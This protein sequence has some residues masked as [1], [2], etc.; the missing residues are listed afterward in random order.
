MSF[1]ISG[2]HEPPGVR[3]LSRAAPWRLLAAR[4]VGVSG[5]V[6]YNWWV[7]VPFRAGLLR[8]VNGFFSDLEATGQP[9]ASLLQH[10]DLLAGVLILAALW[11][12]GSAGRD[13]SRRAEWRWMLLFAVAGA[14]SALYPYACTEGTSAGC[15]TLEW[16]FR[17]PVHHY[18]HVAFGIVEFAA[19]SI[20]AVLAR[21]RSSASSS[22]EARIYRLL[23]PFGLVA[24]PVLGAAYLTDRLGA[25]VEP[26]FF[27]A[28]TL[29]IAT[30]LFEPQPARTQPRRPMPQATPRT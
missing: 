2:S 22:P 21:R 24:Y 7:A 10:A 14:L 13:G 12:R 20:A 15:R 29:F 26:A 19:I 23:V 6:A 5:L 27:L 4:V 25:L 16:H 18:L 17:L 1:V 9:D 11:L 8:S 30:E 28:F 3:W